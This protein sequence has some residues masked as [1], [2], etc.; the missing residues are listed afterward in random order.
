LQ[1]FQFGDSI[2]VFGP[3]SRALDLNQPGQPE[4]AAFDAKGLEHNRVRK[5]VCV[6]AAARDLTQ[7][8]SPS[9]LQGEIQ[10][11]SNSRF[12]ELKG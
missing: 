9:L 10:S 4:A 3:A 2:E 12:I 5:Q 8:I 7:E 6:S 1:R 11:P